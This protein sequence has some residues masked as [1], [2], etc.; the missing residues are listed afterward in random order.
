MQIFSMRFRFL[1]LGKVIVLHAL[2]NPDASSKKMEILKEWMR[3]KIRNTETSVGKAENKLEVIRLL[4]AEAE[5]LETL[6]EN[7]F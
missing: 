3:T 5:A 7:V 6:G 4:E 2:T 1:V